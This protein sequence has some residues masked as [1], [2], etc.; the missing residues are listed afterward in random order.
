M[1][2]IFS[3][4]LLISASF[5]SSP[6]GFKH[7]YFVAYGIS[8]LLD[9]G[10][11]PGQ[12]TYPAYNTNYSDTSCFLHQ[13]SYFSLIAGS[14]QG[15][16]NILEPG[17][18]LAI[19][20]KAKPTLGFSISRDGLCG[21]YI[22]VGVGLEVGNG[23]TYQSTANMGFT[24]TAGYALNINPLF[25]LGEVYDQMDNYNN[26]DVKGSWG[27]PFVS[28]GVRYWTKTNKLREINILYGFTSNDDIPANAEQIGIRG[29]ESLTRF[30]TSY[31][32][33]LT[34]MIY[35]NY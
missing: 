22:P 16:Y 1:K 5:T 30:Q 7:R 26:V 33:A 20:V 3:L 21:F 4:I 19:S 8:P 25:K 27:S 10:T 34:W 9:F 12:V 31:M 24:L 17:E 18:N 35:L 2:T 28:A 13:T 29:D 14:Y 15:R 32:F 6:Q 11:G 23:A